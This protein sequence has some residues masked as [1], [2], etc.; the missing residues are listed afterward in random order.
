MVAQNAKTYN[1]TTHSMLC[2]SVSRV[3]RA[4]PITVILLLL[5]SLALND[6]RER[7][8]PTGYF[9][10]ACTST[11]PLQQDLSTQSPIAHRDIGP[12][13]SWF[14]KV[15]Y[16]A[17]TVLQGDCK[18]RLVRNRGGNLAHCPAMVLASLHRTL[19]RAL[20]ASCVH[21][22]HQVR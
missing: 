16:C 4:Q 11:C 14:I 8:I 5:D 2:H 20:P 18:G 1:A 21:I 19:P 13:N 17:L 15:K 9:P 6:A 7:N 22:L 3:R 10:T 12:C